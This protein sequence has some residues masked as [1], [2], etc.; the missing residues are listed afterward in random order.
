MRLAYNFILVIV[1]IQFAA[2]FLEI[3]NVLY[4]FTFSVTMSEPNFAGIFTI[5]PF[6]LALTGVGSAAITLAAILTRQGTYAI[7][8]MLLFGIGVCINAVQ[9]FFFAIPNLL[10]LL[11]FPN[12]PGTTISTSVPI[13]AFL[14]G[15]FLY[16]A[17]WFLVELVTQRTHS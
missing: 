2:Y 6:T 5:T 11:P 1:G 7:Y 15:L 16:A 4:P 17:W 14:S 12:F 3:F 10:Q 8:A 9:S 13:I